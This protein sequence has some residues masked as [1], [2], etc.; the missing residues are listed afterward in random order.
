MVDR[1][2]VLQGHEIWPAV[3]FYSS[4]RVVRLLK[5]EAQ[6]NATLATPTTFLSSLP[7]AAVNVGYGVLG[8]NGD[9]G[10][11]CAGS[12]KVV[13][14][15]VSPLHSISMHPPSNHD[16]AVRFAVLNGPPPCC[17]L[18][19]SGDSVVRICVL[20]T[21]QTVRAF[22]WVGCVERQHSG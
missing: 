11:I 21:Q 12:R 19:D 6:S 7:E 14:K 17:N 15:N 3:Q 22:Q 18:S 10:F 9:L 16:G 8:K 20:R 13:V 1:E 4:A 2:I 5:F